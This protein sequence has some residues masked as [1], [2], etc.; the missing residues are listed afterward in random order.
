[1]NKKFKSIFASSLAI[2]SI[3]GV[4]TLPVGA[5]QTPLGAAQLSMEELSMYVSSLEEIQKCDAEILDLDKTL[6]CNEEL[7]AS[8]RDIL[9][10]GRSINIFL[11]RIMDNDELKIDINDFRNLLNKIIRARTFN[12]SC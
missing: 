6:K 7:V 3:S 8:Q 5:M 4:S 10:L 2:L 1:M 11:N 9:N 12:N